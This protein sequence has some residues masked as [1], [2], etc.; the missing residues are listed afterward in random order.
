MKKFK[1]IKKCNYVQGYLRYGHLEGVFEA[2]S[3]EEV[4]KM[5]AD[6]CFDDLDLIVDSYSID[7]Y[8]LSDKPMKIV[9]VED[10]E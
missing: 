10:D 7:D 6:G 2:E 9:E 5:F 8:E 3:K 4:E 1:V